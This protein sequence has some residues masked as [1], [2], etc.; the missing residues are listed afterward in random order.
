[1]LNN[2]ADVI[3]D[4]ILSRL[5][6]NQKKQVELKRTELADEVSCAPSQ[7]SYVLSTRFTNDRGFKVESQRGLGGYIR[8]TIIDDSKDEKSLLYE[9][10]LN[11]ITEETRFQDVKLLL[12][13]LLSKRLITVREAEL[14][15]QTAISLYALEKEDLIAPE[16][17]VYVLQSIFKTFS[18]IT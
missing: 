12:D 7:V 13:L 6:D 9:E 17:K 11:S 5:R 15:A 3:E 14:A 16:S 8:I 4:Y 10:I 1:M 2:K 18:K